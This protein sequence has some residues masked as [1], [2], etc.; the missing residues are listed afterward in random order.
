[1]DGRQPVTGFRVMNY[2][3]AYSARRGGATRWPRAGLG[4]DCRHGCRRGLGWAGPGPRRGAASGGACLARPPT[5][6]PT[7]PRGWT[8][9]GAGGVSGANFPRAASGWPGAARRAVTRG[10]TIPRGALPAPPKASS[11]SVSPD[12]GIAA[13]RRVA[14]T[15]TSRTAW[16]CFALLRPAGG[17]AVRG[18][19]FL[20]PR[21]ARLS[22]C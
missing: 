5:R 2:H 11:V 15:R 6:V 8:G 1:M 22:W 18:S 21:K 7:W 4:P 13:S 19:A 16:R 20:F 3:A 9:V 12:G 17:P 10:R 14:A